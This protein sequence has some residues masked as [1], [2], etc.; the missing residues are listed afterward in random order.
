M[1]IDIRYIGRYSSPS[2]LDQPH[3]WIG[4]L[5]ELEEL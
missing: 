4:N 1:P 2:N 3:L 5:N